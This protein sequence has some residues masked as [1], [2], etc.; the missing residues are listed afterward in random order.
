MVQRA[1]PLTERGDRLLV[2]EVDEL[3]G[4][5]RFV[6]VGGGESVGVAPGGDDPGAGVARGK[7]HRLGDTVAP[8]DHDNGPIAQ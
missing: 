5:A 8:S 4:D 2:G 3:G 6:G 1:Q 7:H